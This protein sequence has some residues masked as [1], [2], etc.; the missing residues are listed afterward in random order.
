MKE[1]VSSYSTEKACPTIR[2]FLKN[3]YFL[4]CNRNTSNTKGKK[5]VF[6]NVQNAL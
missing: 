5:K 3:E 6:I 1:L 2:I 4:V